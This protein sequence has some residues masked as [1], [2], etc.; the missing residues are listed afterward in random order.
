M[1][2]KIHI[3]LFLLLLYVQL[4][5][6]QLFITKLTGPKL[7]F[8][9]DLKVVANVALVNDTSTFGL[10]ATATSPLVSPESIKLISD[11]IFEVCPHGILPLSY[12]FAKGQPLGLVPAVS[13]LFLVSFVNSWSLIQY[14]N[15][16]RITG[17]SNI[18][19]I[20]TKLVSSETSWIVDVAQLLLCSCY[21]LKFSMLLGD[22]FH[23]LAI[24][25]ASK[26]LFLRKDAILAFI[27]GVILLP[28]CLEKE[29][30]HLTFPSLVGTMSVLYSVGLL[31]LTSSSKASFSS[32]SL[33]KSLSTKPQLL[34]C[35]HNFLPAV[36][37]SFV[38]HYCSLQYYRSFPNS[39]SSSTFLAFRKSVFVSY[40]LV[41]VVFGV[42]MITG[43][44]LFGFHSSLVILENFSVYD[45]AAVIA[46]LLTGVTLLFAYPLMF[47]N[48]KSSFFRL[49]ERF[50]RTEISKVFS[51]STGVVMILFSALSYASLFLS[52]HGSHI[53]HLIESITGMLVAYLF[54]AVLNLLYTYSRNK[55]GFN[56]E[57]SSIIFSASSLVL[58]SFVLFIQ[59]YSYLEK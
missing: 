8:Y 44:S 4:C 34:H 28:F 11:I 6:S 33:S 42:A 36:S 12:Y 57:R 13:I 47:E 38:T 10:S 48:V 31:I 46:R 45:P 27:H 21:C 40:A 52:G 59:I 54:P 37:L 56:Y 50:S 7:N 41:A 53:L 49:K 39:S 2:L 55:A 58:G 15:L 17:S 29:F 26:G 16:G 9:R 51:K 1:K 22:I 24:S 30:K 43:F 3:Y 23:S 19:D 14:A 20:W 25:N 35:I 32:I 5:D 18:S